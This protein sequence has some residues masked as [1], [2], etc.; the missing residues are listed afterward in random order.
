M[1]P[2]PSI[3]HRVENFSAAPLNSEC[4]LLDAGPA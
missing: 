3:F 2:L 1:S 4:W